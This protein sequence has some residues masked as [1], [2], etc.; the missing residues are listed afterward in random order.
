[1]GRGV[2]SLSNAT[3]VVYQ[4][5]SWIG[6]EQGAT[7]EHCNEYYYH[8]YED[9]SEYE[10]THCCGTELTYEDV[11]R[12][13]HD[14]WDWFIEGL[15]YQFTTK[16]PSLTQCDRWEGREDYIFLENELIEV[17]VAEYCGLASIS[18]RP[19]DNEERY[20]T[21]GEAGKANLANRMAG[22]VAKWMDATIGDSSKVGTFSNGESVYEKK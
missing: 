8:P 13:D 19:I 22:Y 17:G 21:Q 7:C 4:D 20:Y 11:Y 3:T 6:M 12:E 14:D 15:V 16:Y 5:V 1:M 18:V 9:E 10:T 2:S